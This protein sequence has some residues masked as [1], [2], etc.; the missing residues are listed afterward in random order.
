MKT[1]EELEEFAEE[2][3]KRAFAADPN[4][5]AVAARVGVRRAMSMASI[6]TLYAKANEEERAMLFQV[7]LTDAT[8]L[9]FFPLEQFASR[10]IELDPEGSRAFIRRLADAPDCDPRT[11]EVHELTLRMIPVGH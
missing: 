9:P 3:T 6:A 7:L 8:A 4:L 2:I 1:R 5:R 11:R 10:M